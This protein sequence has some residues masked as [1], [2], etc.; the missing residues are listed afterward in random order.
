MSDFKKKT[1]SKVV[2]TRCFTTYLVDGPYCVTI[3]K[4]G[5]EVQLQD[6]VDNSNAVIEI[7]EGKVYPMLVDTRNIKS[8]EKAARDHFS[9]RNRKGNVNSI[10]VLIG[11][12]IS[13]VIGNFF[14]GLNKP[15]VPVKLFTGSD[16]AFKWL[17]QYSSK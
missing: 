2:E 16:K 1:I 15:A 12:P 7:S 6:A 4:N 13:V 9:M 8:I 3:V 14:M 10:A 5:S 11:S 17:E